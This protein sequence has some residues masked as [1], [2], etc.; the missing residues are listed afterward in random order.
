MQIKVYLE[1][2]I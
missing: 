2:K 1:K